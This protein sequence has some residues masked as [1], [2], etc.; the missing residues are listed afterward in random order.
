MEYCFIVTIVATMDDKEKRIAAFMALYNKRLDDVQLPDIE[1]NDLLDL[2]DYACSMGW[3]FEA[4]LYKRIA[5]KK[6]P[7]HPDVLL[8]L[9][10]WDVDN[11]SWDVACEMSSN[12]SLSEYESSLFAVE[13]FLRMMQPQLA[14]DNVRRLQTIS[15]GW[16]YYDFLFDVAALFRD[17]GYM[18]YAMK[19]LTGIPNTYPDFVRVLEMKAE[20]CLYMAEYDEALTYLEQALDMNSFDDYLWNL[21]SLV[22]Y[23]KRDYQSAV[24]ASEYSLAIK[25]ENPRA[26]HLYKLSKLQQEKCLVE[27]SGQ[28][29]GDYLA[30]LEIGDVLFGRGDYIGAE[31]YYMRAGIFSERGSRDRVQIVFKTAYARVKQG[32]AA[33]GVST[34]LSLL[35]QGVDLWPYAMDLLFLL[36][37]QRQ[38]DVIS[39]LLLPLLVFDEPERDRIEQI[40]LFLYNFN[41]FADVKSVWKLLFRYEN[42]LSE[43]YVAYLLKVKD[44]I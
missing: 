44:L 17:F 33:D 39:D 15:D 23:K 7:D 36:Y 34:F 42:K 32:L 1:V 14:Y 22:Y 27:Y 18:R 25:Q 38:T 6:F 11:G 29:S 41:C 13:R 28:E 24:D 26:R 5:E 3:D 43:E 40:I 12:G 30:L 35:S 2:I 4:E 10:H 19:L 20:C 21:Q 31:S 37:R 9:A 16:V 8:L